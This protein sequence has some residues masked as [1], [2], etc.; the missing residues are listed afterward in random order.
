MEEVELLGH[1]LEFV[2]VCPIGDREEMV[3]PGYLARVNPSQLK[4]QEEV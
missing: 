3:S 2:H 1:N 4:V